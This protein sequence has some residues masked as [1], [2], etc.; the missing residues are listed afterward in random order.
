M[1]TTIISG[2]KIYF[3]E[4]KKPFG[5]QK[6]IISKSLIALTRSSHAL[7]ESPTG[8]GKTLA[9]LTSSLSWQKN[10]HN[11]DSNTYEDYLIK[12]DNI[13]SDN[14]SDKT[15]IHTSDCISIENNSSISVNEKKIKTPKY[16]KVFYCSRTHSQ[17]RQAVAELSNCN[18]EYTN[19]LVMTI[20]GSR[21]I[22][23]INK[24]IKEKAILDNTNLDDQCK[25]TNK[26]FGCQYKHKSDNLVNVLKTYGVWDLEDII[27][28]GNKHKG[29]PY[30]S[31]RDI[32]N[33]NSAQI[34][35]A[36]YNYI[37]DASIRKSM[38]INLTDSIIILDEAHNIEE[39][40]RGS[41]SI[42]LKR[43]I[44]KVTSIHL[45]TLSIAG[46]VAF[47]SLLEL[48]EGFLNWLDNKI[49]LLFDSKGILQ[50]FN[51]DQYPNT[52]SGVEVMEDWED[53]FGLNNDTLSIYEEHY[54]TIQSEQDDIEDI[55]NNF[56]NNDNDANKYD[57]E[58]ITS[59]NNNKKKIKHISL[60]YDEDDGDNNNTINNN[61]AN[62]SN[63]NQKL[64]SS[65]LI[66]VKGISNKLSNI[67]IKLINLL[68]Y[69]NIYL[70]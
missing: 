17:L 18:S 62:N 39:V 8:T 2:H 61:D 43:N 52:W 66:I 3:P 7:L 57:D 64:I 47:K 12:K 53:E 49:S 48:I 13:V 15:S 21:K 67:S 51:G 14:I 30:Y 31:S 27:Y 58:D 25:E 41:A 11:E 40:C 1:N 19:D 54:N 26:V 36:P 34:I 35:F 59:I 50:T 37:L 69:L 68:L 38:K 24:K 23:C 70:I 42:D 46:S 10:K 63:N 32:L 33:E 16:N 55:I 45:K 56:Y 6:S 5:S 44:L 22:F 29:C 65:S 60:V 4:G 28:L 20:L 9:L